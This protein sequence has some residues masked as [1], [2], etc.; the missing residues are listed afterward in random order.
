MATMLLQPTSAATDVTIMSWNTGEPVPG[1]A[2]SHAERGFTEWFTAGVQK[3]VTSV[4]I[5]INLSPCSICAT[6]LTNIK[7]SGISGTI[8]YQKPYEGYNKKTGII[9]ENTTTV[10]DLDALHKRL[11]WTVAGPAVRWTD[12]SKEKEKIAGHSIISRQS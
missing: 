10:E 5:N 9:L 11:G 4:D 3:N 12:A 6:N 1:S 2:S 8:T 7:D